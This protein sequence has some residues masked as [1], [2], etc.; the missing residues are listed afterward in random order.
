[1]R[2]QN[3]ST[4][5]ATP[6]EPI[7]TIRTL[8]DGRLV[9]VDVKTRA[10]PLKRLAHEWSYILRVRARWA[11]NPGRRKTVDE[12][13]LND[14]K[15]LG[16]LVGQIRDLASA[17]RIEVELNR[18]TGVGFDYTEL[19]EAASEF[20]WEHLISA[21]TRTQG[22]FGSLLITRLLRNEMGPV[23]P[24]PPKSVLFIESAPGRLNG[25]YEFDDE[26]ERI[27]AAVGA[28]GRKDK[29]NT[30]WKILKTPP[31][32]RLKDEIQ[33]ANWEAVHVTGLDTQQAGWWIE[34]FYQELEKKKPELFNQ[35][36]DS[37]GRL[38]DGMILWDGS[39]SELPVPYNEL[40]GILV[41]RTPPRIVT[42]NMYY[43][44][45]RTAR[46]LVSRGAH[47]AMGFLDEI[48]DELAELFFQA[49][50][51]EW[52]HPDEAILSIPDAFLRAWESVREKGM[53]GTSIVIWMGRS[54]FEGRVGSKSI[55]KKQ[56][57]R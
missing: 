7:V 50:Y 28:T 40:A 46:E 57:A 56:V 39:H 41:G 52:C 32:N 55:P 23:V 21:A 11:G 19:Y 44:G 49:F 10:D 24:H 29:R 14:L 25:E 47:V 18:W 43:S 1:M 17:D 45:A 37:S 27:A 4:P 20:P 12:R 30:S 15:S 3:E 51:W 53:H 42:L 22:R 35:L 54:V 48:D 31:V 16:I 6:S 9:E 33:K 2:S 26:E 13:A 34:G 36:I 5:S 8:H 38:R